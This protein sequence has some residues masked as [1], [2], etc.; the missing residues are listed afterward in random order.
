MLND[1]SASGYQAPPRCRPAAVLGGVAAVF[2]GSRGPL[3]S[4][5]NQGDAPFHFTMQGNV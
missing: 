2:A 3:P 1:P 4:H 5:C